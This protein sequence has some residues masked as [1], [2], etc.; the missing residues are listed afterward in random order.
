MKRILNPNPSRILPALLLA[1]PAGITH[2][3]DTI[4]FEIISEGLANGVSDDGSAVVGQNN[5]GGFI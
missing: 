3:G 5:S 2:A 4:H 1:L